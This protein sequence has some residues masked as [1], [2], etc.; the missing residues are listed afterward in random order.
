[1]AYLLHFPGRTQVEFNGAG[2]GHGP[3][4]VKIT[5]EDGPSFEAHNVM[6]GWNARFYIVPHAP[7]FDSAATAD[8]YSPVGCREATSTSALVRRRVFDSSL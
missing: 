8:M 1:M 3:G 2:V 4:S 7:A 6:V 5:G